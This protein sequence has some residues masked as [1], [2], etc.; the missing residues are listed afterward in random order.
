MVFWQCW[1]R[2]ISRGRYQYA[3]FWWQVNE[4]EV[5]F[6]RGE[7][8]KMVEFPKVKILVFRL[9]IHRYNVTQFCHDLIQWY[10][11][12][13]NLDFNNLWNLTWVRI[14]CRLYF[15][16]PNQMLTDI[17]ISLDQPEGISRDE[18]YFVQNFKGKGKET[19]P[20]NSKGFQPQEG[21]YIYWSPF[22]IFFWKSPISQ[23]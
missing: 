3:E 11:I 20:R 12:S 18:T 2:G 1:I 22:Y 6:S 8:E 21:S 14:Y 7:Q 13:N 9:G 15:E 17:F 4:K 19:K 10:L 5:E 16:H 23:S